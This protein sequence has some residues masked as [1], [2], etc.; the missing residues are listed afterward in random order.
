MT[1]S[2]AAAGFSFNHS[3]LSGLAELDKLDEELGMKPLLVNENDF[4]QVTGR[5]QLTENAAAA[6]SPMPSSSRI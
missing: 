5:S 3:I 1:I 2:E 4:L 6:K